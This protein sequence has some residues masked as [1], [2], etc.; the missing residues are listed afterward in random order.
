MKK[1]FP[2]LAVVCLVVLLLCGAH[3]YFFS[4]MLHLPQGEHLTTYVSPYS[5][6]RLEIYLVDGGATTDYAIRGCAVFENGKK[7]NIYWNYHESEA[8]V[9]W[10][11]A[12]T[13]QINGI[14]L[15]IRTDVYDYRKKGE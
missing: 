5:D 12:D 13:V 2:V 10:L 8:D 4:S 6:A 14:R 9:Q 15:N 1:L 3:W 11:D 7:K